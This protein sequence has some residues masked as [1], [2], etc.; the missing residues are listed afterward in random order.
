MEGFLVNDTYVFHKAKKERD[1]CPN[2]AAENEKFFSILSNLLGRGRCRR[3]HLRGWIKY[4]PFTNW[5]WNCII[6][7][8]VSNVLISSKYTLRCNNPRTSYSNISKNLVI[9]LAFFVV[10]GNKR[11]KRLNVMMIHY[12]NNNINN[13]DNKD[14]NNETTKQ[15]AV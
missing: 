9:F 14:K 3:H 6:I 12:I 10:V 11:R 1:V 13:N 15:I 2:D 4:W 8:I 7:T 5:K